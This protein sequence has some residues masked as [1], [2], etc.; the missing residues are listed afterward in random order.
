MIWHKY[1]IYT[2]PPDRVA[3]SCEV[4]TMLTSSDVI[5]VCW[6]TTGY[7]SDEYS[8]LLGNDIHGKYNF[9]FLHGRQS[10]SGNRLLLFGL[11]K[12]SAMA[13]YSLSPYNSAC[14]DVKIRT[15]EYGHKNQKSYKIE[16]PLPRLPN[17]AIPAVM[18]FG[19][20]D[21][22]DLSHFTIKYEIDNIPGTIDGWLQNDDTD[23]LQI[24]DG[25]AKL[26]TTMPATQSSV[27]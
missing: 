13:P 16:V 24:R 17:P 3:V 5:T 26:A 21:P 27:P 20:P 10:P 4:G 14:F 2:E 18:Y 6:H 7:G 23:K 11:A 25:P 8:K 9:C 15:E 12:F 1:M 22:I 19:Q